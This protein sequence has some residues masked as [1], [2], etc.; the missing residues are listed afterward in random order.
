MALLFFKI[1]LMINT[2]LHAFEPFVIAVFSFRLWYLQNMVFERINGFFGRRKS[3]STQF[4][5]HIWEQKEV[6]RC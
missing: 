3:L 4:V 6:I 2:L 5:L 1:F